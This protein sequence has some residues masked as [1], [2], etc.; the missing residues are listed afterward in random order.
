M[1]LHSSTLAWRIPWTEEP[2]RLQS[3][4]SQRVGHDWVTTRQVCICYPQIP[5]L[6]LLPHTHYPPS[7]TTRC[8]FVFEIHDCFC[9][10][11]KFFLWIMFFN[12]AYKGCHVMFVSVWHTSL[13]MNISS[14]RTLLQLQW[15]FLSWLH[16][17]PLSIRTAASLSFPLLK[18]ISVVSMSWLLWIVLQWT[19]G[20]MHIFK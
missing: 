2:R 14:S 20:C 7:V 5:D 6:S 8:L 9:F 12:S 16:S 11:N 10:V 15:F 19:L 1:A 13:S 18:D 17:T 3:T 4:G